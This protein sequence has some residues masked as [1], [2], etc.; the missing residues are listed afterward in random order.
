MTL[1][2]RRCL[3]GEAAAEQ[4]EAGDAGG[5]GRPQ[6]CKREFRDRGAGQIVGQRSGGPRGHGLIVGH[7]RRRRVPRPKLREHSGLGARLRAVKIPSEHKTRQ[8]GRGGVLAPRAG[9]RAAAFRRPCAPLGS[10][11]RPPQPRVQ[12]ISVLPPLIEPRQLHL[13]T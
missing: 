8:G 1:A 5:G 4:L 3:E 12:R 6:V 7:S 13:V 10:G 2:V 9:K 11:I